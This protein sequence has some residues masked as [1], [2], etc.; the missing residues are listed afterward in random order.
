MRLA[1]IYRHIK[2]DLER[3]EDLLSQSMA[4]NQLE[5]KQSSTHLLR[6]GG[7]RMRPVFVLLSGRFGTS[8]K[9]HVID[10]AVAL[11]LIHMATLVHD[12]VI[13]NASLRRGQPTVKAQW[14]NRVAMYAGDYIISRA[15]HI[16]SDIQI[17]K[18]HQEL[19][20][21]IFLMCE[22]EIDQI[23]D[24]YKPQ[25]SV[26]QYLSRIKR[27]TALLMSIS[28]QLGA[29]VSDA[30]P[31][32]IQHLK[33]YGYY[34]GMAFQLTDDV[35]DFT[36]DEETL[37]KPAGSDLRQGNV[38]LPVIYA[39]QHLPE[40][41]RQLLDSF[42]SSQGKHPLTSETLLLVQKAGGNEFTLELSKRYLNKALDELKKLPSVQEQ[43]LLKMLAEFIVGRNY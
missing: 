3:V 40:V 31:K 16:I 33:L 14:D 34:V 10:V 41:E 22:G 26:K 4:T 17:L 9:Q 25:Q 11:E 36:G 30:P 42:L 21:A 39:M 20:K 18:V 23:R 5:L 35:L 13:D 32:V 28:C 7:K 37:G 15:L 19:S 29:L 8:N 1:N 12:D 24:L 27:K 38:T 43:E 2:K 6:A